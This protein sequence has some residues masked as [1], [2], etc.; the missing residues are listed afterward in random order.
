MEAGMFQPAY[1][2][3]KVTGMAAGFIVTGL[4]ACPAI[5]ADW[6]YKHL[7]NCLNMDIDQLN[8]ADGELC[9]YDLPHLV[10]YEEKRCMSFY[11]GGLF[12][13]SKPVKFAAEL[14]GTVVNA[15]VASA[16][17]MVVGLLEIGLALAVSPLV[18]LLGAA[19][20]F[21]GGVYCMA[22]SYQKG[23]QQQCVDTINYL[24]NFI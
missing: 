10:T 6:L 11:Q 24:N 22:Q 4:V 20:I 15:L 14:S 16:T 19:A 12:A 21:A 17:Y 9:I 2:S 23:L 8:R 1:H 7:G 3:A 13:T 18:L 5:F